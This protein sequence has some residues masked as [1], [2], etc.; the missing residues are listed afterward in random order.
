MLEIQAL[1]Q[2]IS[3]LVSQ[4]LYAGVFVAA[5]IETVF[6]PVPTFAIFPLAGYLASQNHM[7]LFE[8]IGLGIAGGTG[9]T[10]GS[11]IIYFVCIKLGRIALL[12]YLRYAKI[13]DERLAKIEKWFEKYGDKA[14][15]FG[16]MV[17]V[18][19]EMISIPAGLLRMKPA[20]FITYTFFGSCVWSI[21]L[22]LVGYYFGVITVEIF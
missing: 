11:T 14:V 12:R 9:A 2:W 18:L 6:P 8:A 22:T 17:P 4:Y 19:R 20:K 5:I 7:S 3:S 21:A 10:I 15:F 16:R 13:T 1:V